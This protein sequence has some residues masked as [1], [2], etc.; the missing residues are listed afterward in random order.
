MMVCLVCII[1][2][3]TYI[4]KIASLKGQAH[5]LCFSVPKGVKPPP[6]LANIFKELTVDISGFTRPDHGCLEG[7][8]KQGVLLL[9]A[10]LTVEAH[11]ANSHAG[12]GWEKFTDAVIKHISQTI[13]GVVFM[14]WGQYAQKKAECI[15]RKVSSVHL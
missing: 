3:H 8:A 7:W 13:T 4:I 10:V 12:K 14:L 5:G 1:H 9:N 2:T 15:Q 6:S 11:K